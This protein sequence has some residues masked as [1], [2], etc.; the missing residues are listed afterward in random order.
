MYDFR[1]RRSDFQIPNLIRE[2]IEDGRFTLFLFK[3]D[4]KYNVQ[5]FGTDDVDFE[6]VGT[7]LVGV[8]RDTLDWMQ[9]PELR[10]AE[11]EDDS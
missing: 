3:I 2:L 5:L 8:L 1:Q 9:H 11:T 4:D 6:A 10:P 7:S